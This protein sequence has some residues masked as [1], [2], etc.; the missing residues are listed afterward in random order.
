MALLTCTGEVFISNLFPDTKYYKWELLGFWTFSIV[1]YSGKIED[2]MFRELD[3]FPSSGKGE[4]TSTQLGPLE[5]ANPN[6][7]TNGVFHP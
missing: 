2:M 5:R 4:E 6:Q 7:W 1:R 3:L